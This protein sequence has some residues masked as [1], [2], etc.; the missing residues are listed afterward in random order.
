MFWST[1]LTLHRHKDC[2]RKISHLL[3]T[4]PPWC[5]IEIPLTILM[6]D[7]WDNAEGVSA[8]RN[9]YLRT[10]E[11]FP[12]RP[13][14]PHFLRPRNHKPPPTLSTST[15][16]SAQTFN[17]PDPHPIT[18]SSPT[19]EENSTAPDDTNIPRNNSEHIISF[20]DLLINLNNFLGSHCRNV[21]N[22]RLM[23]RLILDVMSKMRWVR[24]RI[25]RISTIVHRKNLCN[26]CIMRTDVLVDM[27]IFLS[28]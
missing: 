18:T 23:L 8:W 4:L 22:R 17:S 2:N 27:T 5:V 20:L 12:C 25:S 21:V 16:H 14:F 19:A 11:A 7:V 28:S 13:T 26:R 24:L 9:V 15:A 10:V 3:F 6:D 1:H